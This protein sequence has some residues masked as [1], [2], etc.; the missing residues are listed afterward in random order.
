MPQTNWR[1]NI[2]DWPG[3]QRDVYDSVVDVLKSGN[4][5][6]Y[7]GDST[8]RLNAELARTFQQSHVTLCSSGPI[9]V[10]FA[11]RAAGI[12]PG[13]EVIVAGYDYPGNFRCVE[14]VGARPVVVDTIKSHWVMGLEHIEA[15]MSGDVRACI[16][17][18]LHG[19]IVDMPSL[20][21]FC[22]DRGIILIEDACQVHGASSSGRPLGAWGHVSVIS[23]G[24]SK[25]LTA[26]RAGAVLTSDERMHQRLKVFCDRG[27]DL[28]PLSELQAAALIPQL[29][30]L[31]DRTATRLRNAYRLAKSLERLDEWLLVPDLS[32]FENETNENLETNSAG[33]PTAN[34]TA[35]YKFPFRLT[36][37]ALSVFAQAEWLSLFQEHAFPIFEPFHVFRRRDGKR[38]RVPGS[39]ENSNDI[40]MRTILL[41]HPI[42]L[43]E[44]GSIDAFATELLDF[45]KVHVDSAGK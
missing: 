3:F 6:K 33:E 24:G 16:V 43:S 21:Q 1:N 12:G 9:A 40:G 4:W 2:P 15:A 23:F 25:L 5:G 28:A 8:D 32:C 13:D 31:S 39:L 7:H 18:H 14:A 34:I 11:L 36:D 35:F 45:I 37:K 38:C 27:N 20:L 22:N 19:E 29:Q 42:L 41:H 30:K 17:S 10:E 44:G 26:G